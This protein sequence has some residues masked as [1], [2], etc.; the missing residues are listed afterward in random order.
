MQSY[1][2]NVIFFY[3][4]F[5]PWSAA[6]CTFLKCYVSIYLFKRVGSGETVH[7]TSPELGACMSSVLPSG[8]TT[9]VP[10]ALKPVTFP[11]K[12]TVVC[13]CIS[14]YFWHPSRADSSSGIVTRLW[15]GQLRS[16]SLIPGR[17]KGFFYL[18]LLHNLQFGSGA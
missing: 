10:V 6:V 7:N 11:R 15:A 9:L 8:F 12:M 17:G 5:M 18:S 14:E 16:Q 4:Y 13:K 3:C 1:K 2:R